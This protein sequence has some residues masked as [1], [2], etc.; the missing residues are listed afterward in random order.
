[1]NEQITSIIE[2][3]KLND[4]IIRD[5]DFANEPITDAEAK[6]LADVLKNNYLLTSIRP[7]FTVRVTR[8]HLQ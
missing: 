6:A 7:N 2:Q 4:G 1:M 8:G 3:L 5:F